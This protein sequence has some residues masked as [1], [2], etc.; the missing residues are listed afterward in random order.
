LPSLEVSPLGEGFRVTSQALLTQLQA[1]EGLLLPEPILVNA[2]CAH[3]LHKRV[4]VLGQPSRR[5][6]DKLILC[7]SCEHAAVQIDSR[8][9]LDAETIAGLNFLH[10]SYAWVMN[11]TGIKIRLLDFSSHLTTNP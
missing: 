11:E 2:T 5:F 3:C 1:G 7:P 10:A 9:V 4:E 6:T 8:E